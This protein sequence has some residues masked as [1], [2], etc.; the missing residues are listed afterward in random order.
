M[1]LLSNNVDHQVRLRTPCNKDS[2]QQNATS[3][4]EITRVEPN[5]SLDLVMSPAAA[6]VVGV[7][8]EDVVA[9]ADAVLELHGGIIHDSFQIFFAIFF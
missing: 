6:A 4:P 8:G 9:E 7:D 3:K 2:K 1:P 5:I